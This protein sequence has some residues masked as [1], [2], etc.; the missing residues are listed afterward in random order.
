MK[1]EIADLIEA[2][3]E[4]GVVLAPTV[5]NP[6]SIRLQGNRDEFPERL[7]NLGEALEAVDKAG[8]ASIDETPDDPS[9]D[10][11]CLRL[12]LDGVFRWM[13]SNGLD[14][15]EPHAVVASAMGAGKSSGKAYRLIPKF[16]HDG[17]KKNM[18]PKPLLK[19]SPNPGEKI[20]LESLRN[21]EM[22]ANLVENS[23]GSAS[24]QKVVSR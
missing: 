16:A 23:L 10:P 9:M 11:A 4:L 6:T 18:R 3:R 17:F 21:K 8:S 5:Q 12:A 7:W 22:Q 13:R 14:V 1:R 2:V 24:T 15:T 19:L 20:T